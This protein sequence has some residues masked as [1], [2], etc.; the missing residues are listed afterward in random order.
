VAPSA[1]T[2][3]RTRSTWLGWIRGA[4]FVLVSRN[5][6]LPISPALI[7]MRPTSG[8]P[9]LVELTKR[10]IW[11]R[12]AQGG[13][14]VRRFETDPRCPDVAYSVGFRD[15]HDGLDLEADSR[16]STRMT[17]CGQGRHASMAA[18]QLR[19]IPR[20]GV[21]DW[22]VDHRWE[23]CCGRSV[24]RASHRFQNPWD[25]MRNARLNR[26]DAFSHAM[27]IVSSAMVSSS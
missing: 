1:S 27:I 5:A 25:G 11:R 9:R 10:K 13:S 2:L 6:A 18:Q 19:G 8:A 15:G 7:G 22:C 12:A 3:A 16:C 17:P 4:Q 20:D 23:S 24:R 14:R 26:E 21:G